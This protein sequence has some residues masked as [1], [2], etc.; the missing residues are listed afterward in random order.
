[1]VHCNLCATKPALSA[2]ATKVMLCSDSFRKRIVYSSPPPP[3]YTFEQYKHPIY[4]NGFKT[5]ILGC[6]KA[7]YPTWYWTQEE[8]KS[9]TKW[10]GF[11]LWY[12]VDVCGGTNK[13]LNTYSFLNTKWF[14]IGNFWRSYIL[15]ICWPTY[16]TMPCAC[17]RTLLSL[18]YW[19]Q[20]E[21]TCICNRGIQ[22]WR[23]EG[24][25]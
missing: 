22:K 24:F 13:C 17:Q 18:F 23:H 11:P 19:P 1:M 12:I 4:E 5:Y 20:C 16:C 6:W 21:K 14:T 8:K 7:P 10:I 3:F 2:S 9:Q 15:S 25:F